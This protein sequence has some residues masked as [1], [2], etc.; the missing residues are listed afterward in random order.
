M[1]YSE[2]I[3]SFGRIR[4]YLR[5][6]YVYGFR[7]RDEFTEKSARSYDNERR[8]I[9]S[10]LGD[11]MSFRQDADGRR[12]FLSVDSR[13]I[14]ENPLYR[15]FRAKSFTDRDI[16]LHFHILDLLKAVGGLSVTG[17]MDEISDRLSEFDTDEM[18]D[19]STVRKKLREYAALGLLKTEKRDRETFYVLSED[20][21]DISSWD[22]AAAFFS[23]AAPLGVIGS[24]IQDRL[25]EK[26]GQFRFKHHYILNA[27]DSEVLCGLFSAIGEGRLVILAFHGQRR[28]VL[29][30]KIYIGTQTG[31]QY[32]LAWSPAR[33]RFSFIRTDR[34]DSMETGGVP[35]YPADLM[36]R[37]EEFRSRVWGVTG[38]NCRRLDHIEMTV[39]AGPGEEH[40]VNR[41]KREK[42]CG[43]VERTDDTHWRFSADVYDACEM[44]PWLRTFTG[45][46][47]ALE[48]TDKRV[49][50]R[51]RGDFDTLA[52]MYGGKSDAVS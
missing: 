4:A 13:A 30:L 51:F 14:P 18:P 11:H 41:L 5:S 7:H 16:M 25:P 46:I 45:R 24:Y 28:T 38:N 8:R 26:F 23:E 31:R 27:L 22:A 29:P 34:I 44:L 2:L 20:H 10:W 3:K 35:E 19:E 1:A 40:V 49:I 48:C 33:D 21:A 17:M 43:T 6:F 39:F 47:S 15:A 42:R 12:V 37:M 50:A 52:Q 32:L 9:D 36:A